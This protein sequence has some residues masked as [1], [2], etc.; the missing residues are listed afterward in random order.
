M[1][2][3]NN[4]IEN[5]PTS[6]LPGGDN[7]NHSHQKLFWIGGIIIL[8]IFAIIGGSF[9][10]LA[11]NKKLNVEIKEAQKKEVKL[12]SEIKEIKD[13]KKGNLMMQKYYECEVRCYE[14]LGNRDISIVSKCKNDCRLERDRVLK[15]INT[16]SKFDIDKEFETDFYS[17]YT[18]D[19]VSIP[20]KLINFDL[21]KVTGLAVY[22]NI[23][24][25][26]VY[27]VH[28]QGYRV[29]PFP[30]VIKNNKIEKNTGLKD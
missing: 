7:Q 23:Y 5:N 20:Y 4:Q 21:G 11:Q 29:V 10:V 1:D 3:Q 28:D 9:Y 22:N 30:Y 19:V 12:K 17:N 25:E 14:E 8:I 26:H 24:S 13:R 27:K 2:N 6:N 16:N 18:I 15:E